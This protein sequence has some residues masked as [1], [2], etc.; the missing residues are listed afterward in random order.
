[1]IGFVVKGTA[2]RWSHDNTKQGG[3]RRWPSSKYD[4]E[5]AMSSTTRHPWRLE[6][7][8]VSPCLPT[9]PGERDRE[10]EDVV[11]PAMDAGL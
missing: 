5:E 10:T 7:P 4:G 8:P 3:I 1:M 9:W 11:G 6:A 2:Q